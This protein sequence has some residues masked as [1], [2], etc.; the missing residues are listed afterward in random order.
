MDDFREWLSDN[1]RYFMLGGAILI[2]LLVVIFGVRACISRNKSDDV[3]SEPV[4]TEEPENVTTTNVSVSTE[5]DHDSDGAEAVEYE[6]VKN[7]P[8][9]AEV[10]QR[11]YKALGEKDTATMDLLVKNLPPSD[12]ISKDYIEGYEVKDIYSVKGLTEGSYVAFVEYTYKCTG[13]E[14]VVPALSQIYLITDEDGSLVMDGASEQNADILAFENKL[15]SDPDVIELK[16]SVE[17][18]Y[19]LALVE[20]QDLYSFLSGLGE[21]AAESS[22]DQGSPEG[23]Y[24]M[25]TTDYVNVRSDPGGDVIGGLDYGQSVDVYELVDDWYRIYFDGSEAYIYYEYLE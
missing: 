9:V 7:D 13:I 19:N 3:K 2:V 12:I 8:D 10:I 1:L 17:N 5:P 25:T 24:K 4:Q 20:N 21:D 16:K 14:A 23:T 11:Y 18:S 22:S 6:F 15:L